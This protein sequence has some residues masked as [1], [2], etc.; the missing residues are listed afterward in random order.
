MSFDLLTDHKPLIHLLNGS[1]SGKASAR[2]VS[3]LSRL[4]EYN[5]RI[6]FIPG[7]K[8][9][10]ACFLSRVPIQDLEPTETVEDIESVVATVD[11]ILDSNDCI[12]CEDWLAAIK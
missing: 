7:G 4:Q 6:D 10:R 2:L 11:Y 1:G 8:N 5:F 12:S 3:L 9:S